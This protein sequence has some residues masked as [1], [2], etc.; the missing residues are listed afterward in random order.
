MVRTDQRRSGSVSERPSRSFSYPRDKPRNSVEQLTV[1]SDGTVLGSTRTGVIAWKKGKQQTLMVSN[2]LP[3]D[4][5]FAHVFDSHDSLW[6]Y[7]AC[8][9]ID[10]TSAELQEWW[11]NPKAKL[12]TRTLDTFDGAHPAESFFNGA[13]RTPDGRLWFVNSSVV[14]MIDPAHM[15]LNGLVPPVRIEKLI[16]DRKSY[17][18]LNYIRLPPL[19]RDLEIDYTGLS[20]TVP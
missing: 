14:Q 16:A 17:S 18:T 7:A 20:F 2:G 6:L 19:T 1:S 4:S 3:C 8:G 13:A 11:Q 5:V 12:L 9:L 10:I 15:A